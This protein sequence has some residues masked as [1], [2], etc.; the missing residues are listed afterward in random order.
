MSTC[1]LTDGTE[2]Q[3][4]NSV[5]IKDSMEGPIMDS[6]EIQIK[7]DMEVQIM[8]VAESKILNAREK[9][10]GLLRNQVVERGFQV[11]GPGEMDG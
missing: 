7:D 3:T 6:V 1:D 9:Q 2:V 11:F 10:C 8:D 4:K 5:L